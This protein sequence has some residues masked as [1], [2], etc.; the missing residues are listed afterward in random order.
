MTLRELTR[1]R[2]ELDKAMTS[3]HSTDREIKSLKQKLDAEQL[4]RQAEQKFHQQSMAEL[5]NIRIRMET[6]SGKQAELEDM[7]KV[8]K[9]R[10]EDLQNKLEDAEIAAHNA[11]RS[12]SYARGQL[13]EVE[14]ALAAALNEQRQAEDTIISLQKELRNLEAKV[15]LG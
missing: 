11:I 3:S 13:E 15:V 14:H 9:I 10:S 4:A 8:H 1:C 12:E 2:A 7:V 6:T 5:K